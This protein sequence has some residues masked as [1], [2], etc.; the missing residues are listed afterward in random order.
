[1][2]LQEKLAALPIFCF[3]IAILEADAYCID[4]VLSPMEL[5]NM[6]KELFKCYA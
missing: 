3:C 6:C 1:M 2:C 4:F 5:L